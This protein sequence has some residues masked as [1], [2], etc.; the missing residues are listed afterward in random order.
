MATTFQIF[1]PSLVAE[2]ERVRGAWYARG[3]GRPYPPGL[4]LEM[5]ET[6]AR[7]RLLADLL[8]RPRADAIPEQHPGGSVGLV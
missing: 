2:A 4:R 1:T 7:L 3:K 5:T 8:C 6:L